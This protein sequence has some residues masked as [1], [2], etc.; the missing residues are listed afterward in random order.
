MSKNMAKIAVLS[1]HTPSL[2]WF[3]MDMM[4]E[5]QKRGYEVYAIGN[6]NESKWSAKF[7]ENGIIYQQINVS[8]NG[9]NPLQD[10][11]TL[12]SIKERLQAIS[13]EKI[14]TFQAKTIIYGT[15]AANSLGITEVYPL[16]AG[17]GS[18]FLN[19]DLKSRFVRAAMNILYRVSLKKCPAVFFQN[20]DDVMIFRKYRMINNQKT[21]LLHGSGVNTE[22][23][24]IMS[25]PDKPAFLC[26]SRLIRDKGVYEYLEA[27]RKIKS[28]YTDTRCMLVGPYDTNPSALKPK[29]VKLFIDAGVEYFGEQEDVRPYIEQSSVFVL[30]SYREGTPKTNLEAMSCGRPVITTDA[31]GCRETVVDGENGYLVPVKDVDAVYQKMKWF[32][33]NASCIKLMGAK[34]RMMV[35]KKF[36][37]KK[38]NDKI[39]KTMGI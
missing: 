38:V 10:R 25:L 23:F 11:N 5:F 29:E 14:F 16:V 2:F 3:R 35:E 8:R 9:V 6:E 27:C 17:M 36:D 26:I 32:I 31:P 1:S 7:K 37:V 22:K 21:V 18:M 4:Q 19:G 24:K 39:C 34:S 15:M 13:P 20:K 12:V 30:P 28:E 33:E